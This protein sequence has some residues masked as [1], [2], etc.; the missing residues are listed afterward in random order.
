MKSNLSKKKNQLLESKEVATE[1]L[2]VHRTRQ[3]KKERAICRAKIYMLIGVAILCHVWDRF[4]TVDGLRN[5]Q[6]KA[7]AI[8]EET[9]SEETEEDSQ[10]GENPSMLEEI[11]RNIGFMTR[12]RFLSPEIQLEHSIEVLKKD[13]KNIDTGNEE[14]SDKHKPK[15]SIYTHTRNFSQDRLRYSNI[16][17]NN[18]LKYKQKYFNTLLELF[19]SLGGYASIWTNKEGSFYVFINSTSVKEH[20]YKILA[21]LL[22]LAE[23]VNVPLTLD[24]SQ[25]EKELVLKKANGQEEHFRV[26]MCVLIKTRKEK[27]NQPIAQKMFQKKAAAVINFFIE[28]KENPVL[29]KEKFTSQSDFYRELDK[30]QFLN[31]PSFLI[32]AYIHHYI[33]KTGEMVLFIQTAHDLLNETMVQE[34]ELFKKEKGLDRLHDSELCMYMMDNRES[35]RYNMLRKA[36]SYLVNEYITEK[37]VGKES[38]KQDNS[39][40]DKCT[41]LKENILAR[42]G[43]IDVTHLTK[44]PLCN[45]CINPDLNLLRFKEFEEYAFNKESIGSNMNGA[46][47]CETALLGLFCW[48]TYNY[49]IGGMHTV[50]HIEFSPVELKN[51]FKKYMCI[52][53]HRTMIKK[54]LS[55]WKNVVFR[56]N[57]QKIFYTMLDNKIIMPGMINILRGISKIA[58]IGDPDKI[59]KIRKKMDKMDSSTKVDKVAEFYEEIKNNPGTSEETIRSLINEKLL[60]CKNDLEK[61]LEASNRSEKS[62][63]KKAKKIYIIENMLKNQNS[64][65]IDDFVHSYIKKEKDLKKEL[66]NMISTYMAE[67]IKKIALSQN[68]SVQVSINCKRSFFGKRDVFGSVRIFYTPTDEH[69]NNAHLSHPYCYEF[70]ICPDCSNTRKKLKWKTSFK[71]SMPYNNLEKINL[72]KTEKTPSII[73]QIELYIDKNNQ[74]DKNCSKLDEQAQLELSYANW[75][76]DIDTLLLSPQLYININKRNIGH[77]LLL[78]A[79]EENLGDAHPLACLAD[80]ILKS[81]YFM[82]S[83]DKSEMLTM[84]SLGIAEKYYPNIPINMHIYI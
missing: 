54:M 69:V 82:I 81:S 68:V 66:E 11:T 43:N 60:C 17:K 4:L 61:Q 49:R 20:K 41:V 64:I 56:K 65:N 24:E 31:S 3:E 58:D 32:Q 1:N 29:E 70:N 76:E 8:S 73:K 84:H 78:Y 83:N 57:D 34:D 50:D 67:L 55:K 5:V 22:L 12:K 62:K 13:S 45:D 42:K 7:A 21:S 77:R 39:V 15:D 46:N 18:L 47:Y 33:E 10:G 51:F 40:L 71:M 23:G 25:N 26:S 36:V 27:E 79:K 30:K 6:I 44:K 35:S 28:N 2:K 63:E 16:T 80:N 74:L 59:D 37:E 72:P 75:H 38:N 53:T 48:A 9:I 52:P 19:P 14:N